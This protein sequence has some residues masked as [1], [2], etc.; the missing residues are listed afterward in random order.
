MLTE[1]ENTWDKLSNCPKFNYAKTRG[2]GA[3][4]LKGNVKIS[5]SKYT[6][7]SGSNFII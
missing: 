6:T 3:N 4:K 7:D 2:F 5:G 1:M